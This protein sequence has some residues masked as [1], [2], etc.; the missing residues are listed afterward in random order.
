[1]YNNLRKKFEWNTT[2]WEGLKT[3]WLLRENIPTIGLL[4][5][6]D[7][8]WNANDTSWNWNN[9]TATNITW[10]SN[11]T[12][13]NKDVA[14]DSNEDWYVTIPSNILQSKTHISFTCWWKRN[15]SQTNNWFIYYRNSNNWWNNS[16]YGIYSYATWLG[17]Y[18]PLNWGSPDTFNVTFSTTDWNFIA[19]T[20]VVWG[21]P[22]V[23]HNS[24]EITI[25]TTWATRLSSI[26]DFPTH[27]VLMA[28]A[29]TNPEQWPD[30]EKLA[31]L[32]SKILTQDEINTL[33]EEWLALLH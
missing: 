28:G 21:T 20:R 27:R 19:V 7:L 17:T 13:Y 25:T 29:T 22:K 23:Y 12:W 8:D 10:S 9:W 4:A 33:Y 26:P 31:K 11:S 5:R 18:F 30:Q 2:L 15:T 3:P 6:W 14:D 1:M 32:Y 16:Y 24:Q